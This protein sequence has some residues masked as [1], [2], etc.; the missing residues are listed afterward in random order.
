MIR[1]LGK[2][3]TEKYGLALPI[4]FVVWLFLR[5]I[6]PTIVVNVWVIF[7]LFAM[8]PTLLLKESWDA[9][10]QNASRLFAVFP[11]GF[12]SRTNAEPIAVLSPDPEGGIPAYAAIPFKGGLWDIALRDKT[13]AIVPTRSIE[14]FGAKQEV[15]V[16]HAPL[17]PVDSLESMEALFATTIRISKE[18]L[19]LPKNAGGYFSLISALLGEDTSRAMQAQDEARLRSQVQAKAREEIESGEKQLIESLR[20]TR[21]EMGQSG[22]SRFFEKMKGKLK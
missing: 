22:I 6:S 15:L 2:S 12:F 11:H 19:K 16:A 5:S 3:L 7:F 20:E 13:V 8:I 1:F 14:T 21:S 4:L 10:I 18:I 17:V 9:I